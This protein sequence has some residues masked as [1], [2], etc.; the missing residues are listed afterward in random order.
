MAHYLITG[1][2]GYVGSMLVKRLLKENPGTRITAVV[3]DLDKARRVLPGGVTFARADIC[4]WAALEAA[5]RAVDETAPFE[6]ASTVQTS[7]LRS[8]DYV[9]HCAAVTSSAEMAAHPVEV[10]RGIVVGTQNVLELAR[11]ANARSVVYLSSMEVYGSL[12]CPA[13]ELAVEEDVSKGE[14]D[15]LNARSCYPLGKRMAENV[16][17]SNYKEYGLPVKIARLAQTFGHGVPAGD[18]RVFSQFTRAIKEGRDVVLHTDGRSMGN[19]CAIEDA[20]AGILTILERGADGEAYNVVNESCTMSIREM[21]NLVCA[22][23]SA[24]KSHVIFDIPEENVHGYAA[25]T[26]LRLS[27]EKLREL[28]WRPTKGLGEMYA[29]LLE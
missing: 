16:C 13:G 6:E 12:D 23:F 5:A 3:R 20:V 17:F 26:G 2:S 4:D 22:R 14:V 19:Y 28:G 8:F 27:S 9:I 21:A 11:H 25:S 15:I 7:S 29:D 1:A 24:G 18:N 10:G